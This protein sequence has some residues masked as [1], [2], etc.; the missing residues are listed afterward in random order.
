VRE[1][2]E[3]RKQADLEGSAEDAEFNKGHGCSEERDRGLATRIEH[4][5]VHSTHR[6]SSTWL[7]Q[8]QIHPSPPLLPLSPSPSSTI[9]ETLRRKLL[10]LQ[11]TS[12]S[13]AQHTLRALNDKRITH[14]GADVVTG[15]HDTRSLCRPTK[16]SRSSIPVI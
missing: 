12:D 3:R 14:C 8:D 10:T 9:L 11:C 13:L 15:D 5:Y 16:Y 4:Y 7:D 6:T 1:M 2:K